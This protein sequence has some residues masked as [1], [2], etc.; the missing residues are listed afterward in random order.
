M[1][2][3]DQQLTLEWSRTLSGEAVRDSD[4]SRG[5]IVCKG[6]RRQGIRAGLRDVPDL[7][8]VWEDVYPR[9]TLNPTWLLFKN[10]FPTFRL[11]S[12]FGKQDT[13]TTDRPRG[14]LWYGVADVWVKF[15]YF[16]NVPVSS[17]NRTLDLDVRTLGHWFLES[18]WGVR[19]TQSGRSLKIFVD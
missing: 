19:I 6:G 17:K 5:D 14:R 13:T 4:Q 15:M 3:S 2:G 9:P 1:T 7:L 12:V 16:A 18:L 11:P 8:K 10:V